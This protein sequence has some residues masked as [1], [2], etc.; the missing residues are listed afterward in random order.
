MGCKFSISIQP[1]NIKRSPILPIKKIPN[2]IQIKY[3]RLLK[4]INGLRANKNRTRSITTDA[5]TSP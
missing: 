5:A 4:S 3:N 2:D 1:E